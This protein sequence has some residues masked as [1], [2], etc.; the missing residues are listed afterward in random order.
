M[1]HNHR[2]YYRQR[3]GYHGDGGGAQVHH[4]EEQHDDDEE[5]A[6]EQRL[7]KVGYGVVDEFRLAEDVGGNL[8]VIRQRGGDVGKVA[9]DELVQVDGGGR[10]LFGYG[11]DYRRLA[12][13]RTEAQT[14]LLTCDGDGGDVGDGDDAALVRADD[15]GAEAVEVGGV[16][17]ALHEVFVAVVVNHASGGV[18][19]HVAGG[20]EHFV[21]GDVELLHHRRRQL[22]LELAHVAAQYRHLADAA[23]GQQAWGDGAI[24]DIA[25]L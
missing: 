12:L 4:E 24:G 3:Q 1:Q 16:D 11:D 10:G 5:C 19:V 20:L 13:Y 25:Q 22:Y 17:F 6:L 2:H 18:H 14:G 9:A 21:N 23:E 8:Y 15:G 7:L